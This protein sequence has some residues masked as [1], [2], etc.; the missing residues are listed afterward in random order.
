MSDK[1]KVCHDSDISITCKHTKLVNF[2]IA[3]T[4]AIPYATHKVSNTLL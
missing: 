3:N 4:T 2:P 1:P